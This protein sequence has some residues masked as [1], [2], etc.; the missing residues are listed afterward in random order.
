MR[1]RFEAERAE[2]PDLAPRRRLPQ[3]LLPRAS[4]RRVDARDADG[5]VPHD[6]PPIPG[7][8]RT[9]DRRIVGKVRAKSFKNAKDRANCKGSGNG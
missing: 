9:R 1:E 6:A 4:R 8:V 7:E 2:V 5:T 3:R